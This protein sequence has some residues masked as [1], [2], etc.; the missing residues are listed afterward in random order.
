[1]EETLQTGSVLYVLSKDADVPGSLPCQLTST[2][3]SWRQM[4]HEQEPKTQPQASPGPFWLCRR[5][6]LGLVTGWHLLVP[7]PGPPLPISP[8]PGGAAI[9]LCG[10]PCEQCGAVKAGSVLALLGLG[11]WP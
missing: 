10:P 1:M 7:A 8:R 5:P 6:S 2:P 11:G 3:P 9:S 4:C